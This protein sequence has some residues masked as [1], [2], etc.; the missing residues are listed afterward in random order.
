MITITVYKSIEDQNNQVNGKKY[1]AKT[2]DEIYTKINND[3]AHKISDFYAWN[4]SVADG[5]S[6]APMTGCWD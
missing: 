1:S 3:I 2:S 4:N 6:L 5:A